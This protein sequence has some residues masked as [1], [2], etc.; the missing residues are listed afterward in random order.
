MR[1]GRLS[2]SIRL[3][4]NENQVPARLSVEP[5]LKLELPVVRT[6]FLTELCPAAGEFEVHST[7]SQ[8]CNTQAR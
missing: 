3:S 7:H 1:C 2:R 8:I 4:Q 6:S 5:I